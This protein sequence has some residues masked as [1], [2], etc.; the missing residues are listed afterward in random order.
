[1]LVLWSVLTAVLLLVTAYTAVVSRRPAWRRSHADVVALRAT[2][3]ADPELVPAPLLERV[4]ARV[5]RRLLAE[6]VGA[7]C[8]A[9]VVL[10]LLLA[11]SAE[12]RRGVTVEGSADG[13]FSVVVSSLTLV[14]LLALIGGRVLAV[15]L[16]AGRE[17]LA[18]PASSGPRLARSSS[19]RRE[20]YVP[21]LETVVVRA[22]VLAPVVVLVVDAAVRLASGRQLA[23]LGPLA[24][25]VALSVLVWAAVE[26]LVQR[27]L[28]QRRPASSALELAWDD[29][30]RAQLLREASQLPLL[31]A[32]AAGFV[33]V[34]QVLSPVGADAVASVLGLAVTVAVLVAALV[35]VLVSL[36]ARSPERY[37]RARLWPLPADPEG[38]DPALAAGG[39]R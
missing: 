13:A 4:G 32:S 26:A 38:A 18:P 22:L 28:G 5:A 17:A 35:G 25:L 27:L 6:R 10:A 16:V 37:V 36:V 15:A 29:V 34:L 33:V 8:G 3:P 23:D 7:L 9:V 24:V 14:A 12:T 39:L 11:G 31:V 2:L 30:L 1:M 21:R 20:D 19:P